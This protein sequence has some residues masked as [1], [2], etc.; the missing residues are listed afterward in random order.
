MKKKFIY[1]VWLLT[2]ACAACGHGGLTSGVKDGALAPKFEDNKLDSKYL[3][4]RG[5]GAANRAHDSKT[6]RRAM[7]RE[8]AIANA[9]QRATEYV[10]GSGVYGGVKVKDAVSVN[11]E[12]QTRVSGVVSR[13]EVFSSEYLQDDGCMV[14]LRIPRD[15]LKKINVDFPDK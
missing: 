6:Q 7:S 10:K 9:Y 14:I 8:A 13:G 12:L 15:E 4:A 11:S 1:F 3:W 5:I 2:L